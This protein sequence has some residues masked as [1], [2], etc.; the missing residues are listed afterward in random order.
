MKSSHCGP[1]KSWANRRYV[2][3]GLALLACLGLAAVIIALGRTWPRGSLE[4][5][6][7]AVNARH[8]LPAEKN[9]A[10]IYD[11]LVASY[12]PARNPGDPNLSPAALAALIEASKMDSCWFPLLPGQQCYSAHQ[13][14]IIPMREWTRALT[15]A[16]K[17]DVASGRIDAAAEKLHC[18]VR[19]GSHLQQQLLLTDFLVGMAVEAS[20]WITLGESVMQASTQEEILRI[21]EATPWE[22]ESDSAK[23]SRPILEVERLI[24]KSILAEWTLRHRIRVW[25]QGLGGKSVEKTI[26]ES[27]PRLLS[28]R[29]GVRLL[30]GLRRYHD[31]N[32]RWPDSLDEIRTLVPEQALIDPF[33][34]QTFVYRKEAGGEFV[35]YSKGPNGIDDN[36]LRGGKADD[37]RIWPPRGITSPQK[38]TSQQKERAGGLE[39]N[40]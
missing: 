2:L 35:L 3:I 14:R 9:A 20:A 33:T 26:E 22:L 1:K 38:G 32:G 11:R 23:V 31:A 4:Q 15:N 13:R 19:M 10:T 39:R 8:A 5:R 6:I 29:R 30:V 28:Q 40:P 12:V 36:G 27:Y 21:A 37:Y 7:A 16:A 18:V 17:Q 34:E 24:A 25:W